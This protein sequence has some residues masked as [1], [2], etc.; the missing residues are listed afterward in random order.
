MCTSTNT[1]SI[2]K[3]V[4]YYIND[5]IDLNQLKVGF[6]HNTITYALNNTVLLNN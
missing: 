3:T 5:D 6:V 4:T 2:I 1:E